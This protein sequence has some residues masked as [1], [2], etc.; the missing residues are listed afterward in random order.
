MTHSPKKH[1]EQKIEAL[2]KLIERHRYLYHVL[3]K[4]EI[5][6]EA[7]DSLKKELFDLEQEYPEF[8]TPDSP[9][10]RIGGKPSGNFEKVRHPK[11][12]LSFNDAFSREDMQAW[13]ERISKLLRPEEISQ[14]DFFCEPK[15]DGLAIELVYEQGLLR[16]GGTRG[17]GLLGENVTRNLK[18][19]ESIP[20]ALYTPEPKIR[21]E[22]LDRGRA[23]IQNI[24]VRGEVFIS[25][26]EFERVN[27]EQKKGGLSTFANPRNMAAGSVRQLDPKV[28]ASRQLDFYAY[29]I[30]MTPATSAYGG[31]LITHASEHQLLRGLGF[32]TEPRCRCLKKLEDVL[33]FHR[34]LLAE[35]DKLPYEI[36]GVVVQINNNNI[37]EK[38]GVVGK[39]PRAAIAYKFPLR[40]STTVIE[41]I[42]VQ[43]GRSGALTPVAI[44]RPVAVGGVT[45]SRATLHNE[46]EVQRLGVK[47][48]DT[49]IIGR[50]GDVIPE[51][52][53][54][55][56]ELRSGKE[57]E[58]N[59]P[60]ECPACKTPVIKPKSEAIWR[61]P[62]PKCFARRRNYFY[63]FVSKPA[64]DIVGLGLKIVERLMEEGLIS[65]PADL[66]Q[67]KEGDLVPLERFAE[68]A[69]QKLVKAIQ[70][71]KEISLPRFIYAL[72]IR[73]VGEQTAQDLAE[74]FSSLEKLKRASIEELEELSD[75]GPVVA[76]SIYQ[77]FRDKDNLKFLSKLEEAGIKIIRQPASVTRHPSLKGKRFTLTGEL[78]T[79]TRDEAK[80]RIRELGGAVSESMSQSTDFVVVGK[81]PGIKY[82]KAKKLGVKIITEKDLLKLLS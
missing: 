62:N 44:L 21:A 64:F 70:E 72:G 82:K 27:R 2:K 53:K 75:I 18:T 47:I 50:A 37:F 63:H 10:Q 77:W 24:V 56:P 71:R 13:L 26:K 42:V 43:V 45:I 17:D 78:D 61:C 23:S 28:T 12:M 22:S 41:D 34:Q 29:D 25:K 49:V 57:K 66:F 81:K 39:A 20:L 69:A 40:E 32:K 11:P 67:L 51:V 46:D 52:V 36:D 3:D 79:M 76:E 8:I 15:F 55:L 48:G 73:N 16:V 74:H 65:D 30:V 4:Q 14:L 33:V 38:L 59:F 68:K 58:F 9:T 80:E 19:I 35:R 6:P 5:S 31:E 54:V 60:K 7:L 1:A